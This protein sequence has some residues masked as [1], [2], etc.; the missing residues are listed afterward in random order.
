MAIAVA[1][2]SSMVASNYP[3]SSVT[4]TKPTGVTAG[5]LLVIV[6]GGTAWG[7]PTG[8][9]LEN[10]SV[11][12]GKATCTGFT[13]G[14][15]HSYDVN[16]NSGVGGAARVNVLY[17]IADASDVA[18]STYSVTHNPSSYGGAAIMFRITGW[19][20]GDPFAHDLN[21]YQAHVQDGSDTL[22]WSGTM[23]RPAQQVLLMYACTVG[24]SD[25]GFSYSAQ[26]S[27]PTATW[28]EAGDTTFNVT[29]YDGGAL[30]VAYATTSATTDLTA[31]SLYKTLDVSDGP[32][33]TV[34]GILQIIDPQ[35]DS[36]T[37]A[38]HSGPNITFFANAGITDGQGTHARV[39]PNANF[40]ATSGVATQPTVWTLTAK[41]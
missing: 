36:G 28:T 17:R 9:P 26:A 15:F 35:S 2:V 41:P 39:A 23:T 31:F 4:L 33:T 22:S 3:T 37:S 30:M 40:P 5:D 10:Y 14:Y 18:A 8:Q 27:T 19:T 6:A 34:T 21:V 13:E 32:E 12:S 24:D 20:T 16:A 38:L 1:S 29:D 25:F 7:T 11:N